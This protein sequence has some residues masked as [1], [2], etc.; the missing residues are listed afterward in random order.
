MSANIA[1]I[2]FKL[3]FIRPL[4]WKASFTLGI[5][6]QI[7]LLQIY[8][9]TLV[10]FSIF[11]IEN[12]IKMT[13]LHWKSLQL[14]YELKMSSLGWLA[15]IGFSFQKTSIILAIVSQILLLQ[16]YSGTSGAFPIFVSF[17]QHWKRP[18]Y[19]DKV[20]NFAIC[21]NA[22]KMSC[23]SWLGLFLPLPLRSLI[24]TQ[25]NNR[26]CHCKYILSNVCGLILPF[27][28]RTTM[29]KYLRLIYI[30]KV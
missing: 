14:C 11:C 7:L 21:S 19:I 15:F 27:E 1:F 5:V 6:W 8:S 24:Y 4:L 18:V 29:K 23:F 13:N 17:K 12:N 3:A 28:L 16:M 22:L 2:A 10:T 26:F 25:L 20:Y 9:G 30:D